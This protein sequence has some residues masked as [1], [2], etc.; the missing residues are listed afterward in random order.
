MT[1]TIKFSGVVRHLGH[2]IQYTA[3]ASIHH[4]LSICGSAPPRLLPQSLHLVLAKPRLVSK[5]HTA[6]HV[7]RSWRRQL[8]M[9]RYVRCGHTYLQDH[10][11]ERSSMG[12][13]ET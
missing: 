8:V 12:R 11:K 9:Y 3:I 10:P 5:N 1:V 4:N 6:H 13:G 2:P 7:E